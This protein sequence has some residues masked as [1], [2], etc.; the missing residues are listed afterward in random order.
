MSEGNDPDVSVSSDPV[1]NG[2]RE[3]SDYITAKAGGIDRPTHGVTLNFRESAKDDI[4]EFDTEA[5]PL[6]IVPDR[7]VAHL[8]DGILVDRQSHD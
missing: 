5:D 3:A 8:D 6:L 2:I 1:N 7:G 4:R